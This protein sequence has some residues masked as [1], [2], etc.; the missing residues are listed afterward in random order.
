MKTNSTYCLVTEAFGHGFASLLYAQAYG[1][2]PVAYSDKDNKDEFTAQVN[3]IM[4]NLS[5]FE[6]A[7]P[8][9]SWEDRKAYASEFNFR[10]EL[11]AGNISAENWQDMATTKL[12]PLSGSEAGLPKFAS[13]TDGATMFVPQKLVSDEMCG[14]TAA[15]Q[16]LSP[17]VFNFLKGET[18]VLGQ[19]FHKVNDL[20]AVEALARDFDL[21]VPGFNEDTEVLGIRGV[22]HAMYWNLYNKVAA[23]VG[24][25][26]THTWYLLA[27]HPEVPQ[28]ILYNTKTVEKWKDI[29]AA[30]Q[31]AGS[32]I[33]C[34]G[35]DESTN[36]E[37][38]SKEIE[39]AYAEI[40]K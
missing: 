39:A 12:F 23:C 32:N 31:E 24:I 4:A 15:Q 7:M 26:G 22:K 33:R 35:F 9:V 18:L 29:E 3:Q 2:I 17:A 1:M 38:L 40:K 11:L 8:A 10:K 6:P 30:W 20:P 5:F 37:Q 14:T 36:M 13:L 19:H 28:V 34:I 25:A 21:Y 16:S 27:C